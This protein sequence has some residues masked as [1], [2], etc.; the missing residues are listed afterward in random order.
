M[1]KPLIF[2]V[3]IVLFI[4][5]VNQFFPQLTTLTDFQMIQA[6]REQWHNTYLTRPY[7][8]MGLFFLF[9]MLL[10]SLPVPGISMLSFLAGALFGFWPGFLL[11]SVATAVGNLGG[12][13]LANYFLRDWVMEKYG[14]KVEVFKKD[15]QTNGALAL[16]SMR[17]FPIVPSFIANL[18]LGVSPLRAWTFF[19]VGWLGRVPMVLFYTLAGVQ[20][21]KI[22]SVDEILSAPV[23]ISFALLALAPWILKL[24]LFKMKKS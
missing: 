19:W 4:L 17:L 23:L 11:S 10:A 14:H 8:Y 15:W 12:Y 1:K 7:Y 6:M 13:Y 20:I 2:F 5:L 3:L 16:F 22:K 9:N 24:I 18:V 21:A